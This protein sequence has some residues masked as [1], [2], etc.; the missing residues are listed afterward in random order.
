[1][2]TKPVA[3]EHLVQG[4]LSGAASISTEEL[5]PQAFSLKG[6]FSCPTTK[7]ENPVQAKVADTTFQA[8]G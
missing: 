1:M 7:Q 2:V 6:A 4:E 5:E 8:P 3:Q